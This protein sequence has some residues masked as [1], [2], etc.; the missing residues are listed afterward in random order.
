MRLSTVH[1]AKGL[2]WKAVIVPWMSDGLF[3]SSRSLQDDEGEAEERRLFYV[4]AT[5]AKDELVFCMPDYRVTRDGGMNFLSPSRFIAEL[6]E[7][8][9]DR[10]ELTVY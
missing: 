4:C 9:L 2:E 1:Q 6:P 5:R 10:E 8:L 7:H 3:P